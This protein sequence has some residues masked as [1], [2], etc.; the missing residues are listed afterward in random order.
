MLS[1]GHSI[2]LNNLNVKKVAEGRQSP[3]NSL[4]VLADPPDSSQK[5]NDDPSGAYSI[6]LNN[7]NE[8]KVAE[9]RQLPP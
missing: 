5:R 1:D 4:P 3:S 8:K 6:G 2:G 9:E 7:L